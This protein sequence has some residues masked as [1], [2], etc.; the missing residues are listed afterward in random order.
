MAP[1][2][3]TIGLSIENAE[4]IDLMSSEDEKDEL[5][6]VAVRKAPP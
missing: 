6:T 5:S 3:S 1:S 2:R 4:I